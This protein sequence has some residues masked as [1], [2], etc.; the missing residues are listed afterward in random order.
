M[1]SAIL[2]CLFVAF[3]QANEC[4]ELINFVFN[5][6]LQ[7]SFQQSWKPVADAMWENCANH[8]D[9]GAVSVYHRG[10]VAVYVWCGVKNNTSPWTPDTLTNVFSMTKSVSAMSVMK[11]VDQ[12]YMDYDDYA[13]E[14][15]PAFA[16]RGKDNITIGM[17]TSHA[18]ALPTLATPEHPWPSFTSTD[19]SITANQSF[20]EQL[21]LEQYMAWESAPDNY[22]CG[23]HVND[24][25]SSV[26]F[27]I[28]VVGMVAQSVCKES[29]SSRK[30]YF[31][32]YEA[33]VCGSPQY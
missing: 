16:S 10:C 3:I 27:V 29:G 13:S 7:G 11:L 24:W 2:L 31:R 14:Y 23:Y 9:S 30:R 25:V 1:K 32:I 21:I 20:I 33:R 4:P 17:L 15:W 26:R 18:A 22:R 19:I 6:T 5:G 12:G 28:D 8:S